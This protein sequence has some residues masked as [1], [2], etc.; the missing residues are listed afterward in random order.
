[1]VTRPWSEEGF[2]HEK[3]KSNGTD[4]GRGNDCCGSNGLWCAIQTGRCGGDGA[5]GRYGKCG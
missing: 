5:G 2:I 3:E 4:F 1:M